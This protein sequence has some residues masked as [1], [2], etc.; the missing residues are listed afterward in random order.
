MTWLIILLC[1]FACQILVLFCCLAAGSDPVS[2]EISDKEQ[3]EYLAEWTKRNRQ[4]KQ[5]KAAHR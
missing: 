2:R 3:M 4:K 5:A 1:F